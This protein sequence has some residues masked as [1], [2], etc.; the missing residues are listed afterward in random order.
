MSLNYFS[1]TF[2]P[3]VASPTMKFPASFCPNYIIR[4]RI[5][6]STIY[7]Q[8]IDNL[9]PRDLYFKK[10]EN[11]PFCGIIPTLME[12]V[13]HEVKNRSA[14]APLSRPKGEGDPI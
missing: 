12:V 8:G 6:Q 3:I 13:F 4:T 10:L 11:P 1:T 5:L 9:S 2:S 14:A 7:P